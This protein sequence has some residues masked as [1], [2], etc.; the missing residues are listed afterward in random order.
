MFGLEYLWTSLTSWK[1]LKYHPDKNPGQELESNAKF[2][3]IKG[4]NDILSDPQQRLEYDTK[5]LR[6]GY[7]KDYGPVRAN[8]QRK[9]PPSQPPR[10]T[11]TPAPRPPPPY[12]RTPPNGPSSGARR[13]ANHARA[14]P[15]WKAADEEQTRADAFRAFNNMR[16][17]HQPGWQGFD[18]STGRTSGGTPG[19]GA[20]RNP[21][22]ASAQS[23][24]PKSAFETFRQAHANAQAQSPKKKTGFAPASAGGD[25]PM[26]RNTSAYSS[27][28]RA[29]RPNSQFFGPAPPPTAKKPSEPEPSHP[30][31]I[32]EF[33]RHS[34]GYAQ[35]GK[36]EKTFLSSSGLGR[37]HTTRVPSASTG[38]NANANTPS[39]AAARSGRY[40]SASPKSRRQ[41]SNYDSTSSSESDS[42]PKRT[43]VPK[44]RLRPGQNFADF[45]HQPAQNPKNG[46]DPFLSGRINF[47]IPDIPEYIPRWPESELPDAHGLHPRPQKVPHFKHRYA[48]RIPKGQTSHSAPF[49]Q[50]SFRPSQHSDSSGSSSSIKYE[51]SNAL[52]LLSLLA[53][54]KLVL[55]RGSPR[56]GPKPLDSNVPTQV[57][58]IRNFQRKIGAG[59]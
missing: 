45:H 25:E 59:S 43:A 17:N 44:S 30:P 52:D 20:Q 36:G 31:F 15:E 23:N 33:E 11:T 46:E 6:A 57:T 7:G 12:P 34:R 42:M 4:A 8:T 50:S 3:A 18:P 37:S 41:T 55:R 9:P 49:P 21:F 38:P 19:P 35:A 2:Q 14:G 27:T 28:S 54:S 5:R 10:S 51:F 26:A 1:A 47:G 32:P 24:R 29:D 22:G 40:R 39:P 16:G 58:C 56:S 53:D 48:D 13:Y